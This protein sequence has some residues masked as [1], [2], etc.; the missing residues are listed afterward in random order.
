MRKIKKEADTYFIKDTDIVE[1]IDSADLKEKSNVLSIED[2]ERIIGKKCPDISKPV[3]P[4][5]ENP[6]P[7]TIKKYQDDLSSYV[8]RVKE[9]NE[10]ILKYNQLL[11]KIQKL[12]TTKKNI[13]ALEEDLY[14]WFSKN[15]GIFLIRINR[16]NYSIIQDPKQIIKEI[17]DKINLPERIKSLNDSTSWYIEN[18]E[19]QENFDIFPS[20]LFESKGKFS[21]CIISIPDDINVIS[22]IIESYVEIIQPKNLITLTNAKLDQLSQKTL[23]EW[24]RENIINS[25]FTEDQKELKLFLASSIFLKEIQQLSK[26]PSSS[27]VGKLVG[28]FLEK[29]K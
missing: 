23:M 3:L 11:D 4:K 13:N 22:N 14:S 10:W 27:S 28:N 1:F 18:I 6:R 5:S 21:Y 9:Y 26:Y 12:E 15:N 25:N 2:A 24:N 19:L 29:I 16:N 20:V 8:S 17:K 7:E